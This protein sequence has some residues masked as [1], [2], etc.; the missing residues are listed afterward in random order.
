MAVTDNG[1]REFCRR[2]HRVLAAYLSLH[3]W[4][5]GA[6]FVVIDRRFLERWLYLKRFKKAREEWFLSDV[7]PWFPYCERLRIGQGTFGSYF[8]SRRRF[9]DFPSGRMDDLERVERLGE[10]NMVGMLAD[11]IADKLWKRGAWP[12]ENYLKGDKLAMQQLS[13][14]ASGLSDL[15]HFT[16]KKRK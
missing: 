1:H 13:A 6:D 7:K 3:V 5:A 2:Q 8:L 9:D 16:P 15:S 4:R 14:I 11:Q 10:Q 12:N